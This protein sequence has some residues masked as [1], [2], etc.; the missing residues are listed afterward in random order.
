MRFVWPFKAEYLIIYLDEDYTRTI[1]GRTAR[2]YAWIMARDPALPDADLQDL[3]AFL[4]E[5]GYDTSRVRR[6]P[7]PGSPTG[8]APDRSG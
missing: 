6:M 5:R 1:I 2:D 7:Q 3:I 4:S 8:A